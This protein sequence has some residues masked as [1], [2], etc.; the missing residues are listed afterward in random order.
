MVSSYS[1]DIIIINLKIMLLNEFQINEIEKYIYMKNV[2]KYCVIICLFMDD[3]L[4][5]DNNDYMINFT[6]KILTNKFRHCL[7]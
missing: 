2:N 6:N 1:D 3:M 5:L 4:I 7:H